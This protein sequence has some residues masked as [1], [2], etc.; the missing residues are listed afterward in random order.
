MVYPNRVVLN[1]NQKYVMPIPYTQQGDTARVLTF[2][3]LD[4]G[5]PFSLQGKTV[6]AKIVKP[7]NTKCYNDLTITNATNGEC[8][9]KLTNQILAVAGKV[10][11]QL[12]IKE[13]EELLS[14]IIF[15]I[16]VEPSIDINGA[17]E[18][19][20]EFTALLNGIIK[21]DEWDKYFKETSGAIEE[22]YT[23]RLNGIDSSLEDIAINVEQFGAVGDGV[24][25]DTFAFQNAFQYAKNNNIKK[26]KG[27]RGKNYKL[28][29]I[30][31][32]SEGMDDLEFDGDDCKITWGKS[33]MYDTELPNDGWDY[34]FARG[35]FHIQGS[36]TSTKTNIT[37][38]E[39]VYF[40]QLR[41]SV[42][43]INGF[44]VGDY[45]ILKL[46]T[47]TNWGDYDAN[48]LQ[49]KV[50]IIT[51]VTKVEIG[52]ITLEYNKLF[53]EFKVGAY[54]GSITKINVVENV[55]IKNVEFYDNSPFENR[56]VST[57]LVG[58]TK[59]VSFITTIYASNCKFENIKGE[60]TKL[61]LILNLFSYKP[62]ADKIYL[63][64][65]SCVGGGEG[66]LNQNISCY[67]PILKNS[68]AFN[69]RHLVDFTSCAFG[70]A[71]NCF[72]NSS[73]S[74]TFLCHGA[75][76]HDV[77]FKNCEGSFGFANSGTTFGCA[78]KNITLENC[79]GYINGGYVENLRVIGGEVGV[80]Q[81]PYEIE[82]NNADVVWI[83]IVII[84]P[85]M[86]RGK[87][88]SK[89]ILNNCNLTWLY[90][91]NRG[92][93]ESY[94]V[95][96][97]NNCDLEKYRGTLVGINLKNCGDFL[98]ENCKITDLEFRL[99]GES[100]S[101]NV[102]KNNVYLSANNVYPLVNTQ[103]LSGNIDINVI[104]NNFKRTNISKEIY[105]IK[106]FAS[107]N[108]ESTAKKVCNFKGN[109]LNGQFILQLKTDGST[110]YN[111]ENKHVGITS[112]IKDAIPGDNYINKDN[113]VI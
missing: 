44:N 10:N 63:K 83:D 98:C 48:S 1:I 78:D 52:F 75:Y 100:K 23:E 16:D 37:G 19:T 84:K 89:F 72:S 74:S 14:T 68:N 2:N 69:E 25:W 88:G 31:P 12:E 61:P 64:D 54:T 103:N 99:D 109:T 4:N 50:E 43:N 77:V 85:L 96:T 73:L 21:L 41:Y 36:K 6:R 57:S 104:N 42:D 39:Y 87:T 24:A 46:Q 105:A 93:I 7:D 22:K 59:L 107:G 55:T 97:F 17:V 90:Y 3:I 79:R 51:K 111:C 26:I 32:I 58:N 27:T 66:Y 92:V 62:I 60:N 81:C 29:D 5:V 18:S 11:C 40:N 94:D 91:K 15:S 8:A 71:E 56:D 49:P 33:T 102:N 45:C 13:G 110:I 86:K 28:G 34:K 112:V 38:K 65:P 101:F 113:L 106:V 20:N 9:L 47:A 67:Y 82:F 30:I 80:T 76:E 70:Y 53:W 35:V 108:D 95:V